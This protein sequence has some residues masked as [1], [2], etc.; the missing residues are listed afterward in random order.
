MIQTKR[1]FVPNQIA[2]DPNRSV[3][4]INSN[5]VSFYWKVL[6]TNTNAITINGFCSG[7]TS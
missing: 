3:S 5:K 2:N 6:L 4:K 1:V 7:F